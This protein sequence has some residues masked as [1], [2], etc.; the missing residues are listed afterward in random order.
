MDRCSVGQDTVMKN[1]TAN[2][3]PSGS[4]FI[5]A[6]IFNNKD[7]NTLHNNITITPIISKDNISL[8]PHLGTVSRLFQYM[9]QPRIFSGTANPSS[10]PNSFPPGCS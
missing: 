5:L 7:V 10:F 1:E 2:G 4:G 8:N 6:P 3:R 9:P